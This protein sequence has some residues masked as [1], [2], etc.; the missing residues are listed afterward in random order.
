MPK[1]L[2]PTSPQPHHLWSPPPQKKKTW[3]A[4]LLLFFLLPFSRHHVAIAL[5]LLQLDQLGC[6]VIFCAW[7]AEGLR[8]VIHPNK[9]TPTTSSSLSFFMFSSVLTLSFKCVFLC[10]EQHEDGIPRTK[11]ISHWLGHV[12][13]L[14]GCKAQRRPIMKSHPQKRPWILDGSPSFVGVIYVSDQKHP[15]KSL[16]LSLHEILIG[17]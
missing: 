10:A 9:N 14:G 3:P 7:E 13:N 16:P 8:Q 2:G 4:P 12:F 11:R 6:S 17:Y 5:A 15:S 1:L